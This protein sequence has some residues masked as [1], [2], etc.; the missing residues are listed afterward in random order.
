MVRLPFTH[1]TLLL[2]LCGASAHSTAQVAMQ[3]F[4]ESAGAEVIVEGRT[5]EPDAP[6]PL[7]Q[8]VWQDVPGA[9]ADFRLQRT[10]QPDA[11]TRLM[12]DRLMEAGIGAYLDARVHFTKQG[13][14]SDLPSDRL[15]QEIDAMVKAAADDLGAAGIFNGLSEPTRLQLSR[16]T[17]IDWSQARYGVDAGED[18]DKYLAIYYYV[19]TQREELERQLRADLLPLASVAVLG[20]GVAE[21]G[22][23][24]RINS[25]CGTVFDEQNY[26]CALDLQLADTGDGGIDPQLADRLMQAMEE[27]GTEPAEPP[28]EVPVQRIRKRDRWLKTELDAINE[29]I[30]RMDQRKELWAIRDR[31]EDIEDR[32]TGLELEVRDGQQEESPENPSADLSDLVGQNITVRFS[33]ASV[34]LDPEH[35]VLLNEVFEQ[36]ARTPQHRVLITGYSDRSGDPAV[37]LRLSE[38]R[39]RVVR[40]YLLQR[41]I[42]ADRLMVNFYGDSRSMGRDPSER[43]VEVE[44]IR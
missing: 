37:N 5:E 10:A 17:H 8:A 27:R 35:R 42:S 3:L 31:V 1:L 2:A 32:L 44:W 29:R 33:R 12:L 13:V 30:D 36:L 11:D 38:Q 24:V 34:K 28:S 41:G 23:Q 25:T 7:F 21:P 9:A 14:V 40:N 20:E 18:Q 43:R 26:L 4:G 39:A 15:V 6:Q 19:R 16:L 22:S